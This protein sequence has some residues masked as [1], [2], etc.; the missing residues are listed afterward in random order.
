VNEDMHELQLFD[1]LQEE[2]SGLQGS[3][4]TLPSVFFL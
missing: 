3:Q 1:E 2:H 4:V